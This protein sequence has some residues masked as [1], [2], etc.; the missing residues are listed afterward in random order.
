MQCRSL[1]EI[2]AFGRHLRNFAATATRNFPADGEAVVLKIARGRASPPRRKKPR[3]R[4][5][6][7][8]RPRRRGT[9]PC[10]DSRATKGG[11]GGWARGMAAWVAA[12]TTEAETRSASG[13]PTST[14][15]LCAP[16]FPTQQ[17]AKGYHGERNLAFCE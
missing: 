11:R 16:I 5:G 7:L 13:K 8:L 14:P 2:G 3:L 17:R 6:G 4:F 10:S 1:K 9:P 12:Q 15:L